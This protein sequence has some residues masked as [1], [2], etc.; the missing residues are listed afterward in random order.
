MPRGSPEQRRMTA[1]LVLLR[2]INVGGKNRVPMAELRSLLE[3]LGFDNVSTYVASGNVFLDSD[4]RAANVAAKIEAALPKAF[5]LDAELIKVA[6]V[7]KKA[8]E[9]V[10]E[11]RPKGF[12]DEPSKYH[13]DAIFLMGIDA[14]E[15]MAVFSPRDGVDKVWPGDGVIYHQRLSAQRTK[16]RLNRIMSTPVYASAT[17]RS[18]QTTLALRDLMRDR[19]K[20]QRT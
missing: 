17:I 8:L 3:G 4:L 2:G 14:D 1:Y 9:A 18:W 19:S 16:S 12:G 13:S 20:D 5:K 10:V 7:S 6:V 15:A 11:K